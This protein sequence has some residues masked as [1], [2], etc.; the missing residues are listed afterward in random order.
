M[1]GDHDQA[2]E[3]ADECL[4]LT[5]KYF[6][7]D[8]YEAFRAFYDIPYLVET[9]KRMRSVD[10]EE[11]F[12][13]LYDDMRSYLRVENLRDSARTV[14]KS[15]FIDQDTIGSTHVSSL[16]DADGNSSRAPYPCYSVIKRIGGK[17]K[18]VSTIYAIL[19]NPELSD[20]IAPNSDAMAKGNSP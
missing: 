15:E 9:S 12:R 19:D 14:V 20:I 1:C 16:I 3:I 8:N 7:S 10:S 2:V 13:R 17:W 18:I 11:E 4:Y 5:G 6:W